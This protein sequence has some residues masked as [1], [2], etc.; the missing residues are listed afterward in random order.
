MSALFKA[1]LL[2]SGCFS[3][4]ALTLSYE[5]IV[6]R[7]SPR[8]LGVGLACLFVVSILVIAMFVNSR[9][10]SESMTSGQDVGSGSWSRKTWGI[11]MGKM[12]VV[13]LFV[14]FLNGLWH[15]REKP[16]MPR[17]IGLGANLLGTITITGVVRKLQSGSK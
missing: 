11:L 8:A 16:L 6:G 17:L 4:I 3:A 15:I 1:T 9:S 13:V 5:F 14:L 10:M 12:A 2:F 7:I